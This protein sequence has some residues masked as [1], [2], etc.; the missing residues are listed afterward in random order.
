[1]AE[2]GAHFGAGPTLPPVG[3]EGRP[4]QRSRGGRGGGTTL[5]PCLRRPPPRP[6]PHLRS[7]GRGEAT[8]TWLGRRVAWYRCNARER[9]QGGTREP[10][11]SRRS[12]SCDGR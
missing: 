8:S 12:R 1:M 6:L 3:G 7:R 10:P 5:A 9:E 2:V 11:L 4:P